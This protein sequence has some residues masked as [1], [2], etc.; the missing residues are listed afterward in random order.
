MKILGREEILAVDDIKVEAVLIPEWGEDVG[1][2][3]RG[4]TGKERD[5]FEESILDQS[6][7]KTKVTM[8]NARARLVS[9]TVVDE[10]GKRVFTVKDIEN[11]GNKNAGA[12]DRIYA[13]ASRLSGITEEDMD[14]LLKNSETVQSEDSTSD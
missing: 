14:E 13:V 8:K 12:L 6:G 9:M 1:V 7:K 2:L 11:L 10:D 5:Q 4:M 3:V